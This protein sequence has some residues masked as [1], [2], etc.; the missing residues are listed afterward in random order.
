MTNGRE[1]V[2]FGHIFLGWPGRNPNGFY[3]IR[4]NIVFHTDAVD[5]HMKLYRVIQEGRW[6]FYLLTYLLTPWCRILL[7]KL[8][9]FQVVKKFPAFY[10]T[11]RF[12]T[13]FTST[14]HLSLSW[15][16]SIQSIPV[17][18]TSWRSILILCSHLRL[19]FPNDLFPPGFPT[20]T[21]YKPLFSPY[22]LR[23]Q[24]FGRW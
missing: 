11:R 12:I 16:S 5:L 17:H 15:A 1:C 21:L 13:A 3:I 9:G 7:E 2:S 23:G 6:I 14:R 10:G 18:P 8:N 24:Y 22:A 4:L 20:R 19:G